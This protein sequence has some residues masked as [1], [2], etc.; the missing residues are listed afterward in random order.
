MCAWFLTF[1]I[2]VLLISSEPIARSMKIR[3]ACIDGI[4]LGNSRI[5]TASVTSEPGVVCGTHH[6]FKKGTLCNNKYKAVRTADPVISALGY[7]ALSP[8]AFTTPPPCLQ[9]QPLALP[10]D[11][12]RGMRGRRRSVPVTSASLASYRQ[13]SCRVCC[14]HR[15][16]SSGHMPCHLGHS[17][18][19]TAHP[20][21]TS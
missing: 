17:A 16:F 11:Q 13:A 1:A 9:Q 20:T 5:P 21:R 19:R 7:G 2:V 6:W 12:P 15:R 3:E 8:T 10:V 18:V 14:A 4:C